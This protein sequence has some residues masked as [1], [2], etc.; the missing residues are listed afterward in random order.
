MS[1]QMKPPAGVIVGYGMYGNAFPVEADGYAYVDDASVPTLTAQGWTSMAVQNVT[2]Q[3]DLLTGG[4][5]FSVGGQ[6]ITRSGV[7][8][9][10]ARNTRKWRA[11]VARV[12]AGT[13]NAILAMLGDSTIRGAMSSPSWAGGR[14]VSA[15]YRLTAMLNSYFAPAASDSVWCDGGMGNTNFDA[16]DSRVARGGWYSSTL[17][18]A[19]GNDF[20]SGGGAGSGFAFTPTGNWDKAEIY[21]AAYAYANNGTMSIKIDGANPVEGA[22]S[23]NA[24]GATALTKT[25]VTAS[26]VGAHTITINQDSRAGYV[27]A[28]FGIRCYDST[29]KCILVENFGWGGSK[30]SDWVASTPWPWDPMPMLAAL[31]PDL[32]T[33]ECTINAVFAGVDAATWAAQYQQLITNAKLTGDCIICL[34]HPTNTAETSHAGLEDQ[35]LQA[36]VALALSNDVP[37]I[38][39]RYPW[40]NYTTANALGY[41]QA[42]KTHGTALGYADKAQTYYNVL[43]SIAS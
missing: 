17:K 12:R 41:M 11:A 8:N 38:D 35:Y 15:P 26:A 6:R 22:V 14:I 20:A 24:N 4:S 18:G 36:A 3:T 29:T 27:N 19:G 2:V 30:P 40:G 7:Y 32:T 5:I 37:L 25:V 43:T 34:G 42:D 31:T 10:S 9:L 28:L 33:I 23:V 39:M 21:T 13:G 16:Y 1:V